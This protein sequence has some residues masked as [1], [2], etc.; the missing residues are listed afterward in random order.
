M[1]VPVSGRRGVGGGDVD[2]IGRCLSFPGL[3]CESWGPEAQPVWMSLRL[4]SVRDSSG[5]TAPLLDVSRQ[6]ETC[7]LSGGTSVPLGFE[8]PVL[9]S[10]WWFCM[11]EIQPYAPNTSLI[12]LSYYRPSVFE[13][14]FSAVRG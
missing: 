2:I 5:F 13:L 11:K 3:S 4:S 12:L 1:S 10:S 14:R 6:P 7:A 9:L 8:G